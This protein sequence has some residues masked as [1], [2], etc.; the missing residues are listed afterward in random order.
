MKP[1]KMS[2]DCKG[3]QSFNEGEL[4]EGWISLSE[5]LKG[6]SA[7]K[8]EETPHADILIPS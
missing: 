1:S 2:G 3:I 6:V 5:L 4:Q 7:D 8:N